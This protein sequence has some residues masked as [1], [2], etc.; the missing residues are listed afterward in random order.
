[1]SPPRRAVE[2]YIGHDLQMG[3]R[4]RLHRQGP[5]DLGGVRAQLLTCVRALS[6]GEYAGATAQANVGVGLGA[7]V[8][9]GGLDKSIALQPLSVEGS[10][11]LNVAAGIGQIS[12]KHTQRSRRPLSSAKSSGVYAP[13]LFAAA[14]LALGAFTPPNS[15][16]TSL[17]PT[18]NIKLHRLRRGWRAA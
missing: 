6:E 2:R 16:P 1:M 7:N 11:G 15:A 18:H 8:L 3:R 5:L 14:H 4:Y 12:L 10:T 13:G 17:R 9:I